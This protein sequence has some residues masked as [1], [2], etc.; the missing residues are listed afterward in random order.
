MPGDRKR[1]LKEILAAFI[2]KTD[3]KQN[4]THS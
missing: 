4:L 1:T 3:R 2:L